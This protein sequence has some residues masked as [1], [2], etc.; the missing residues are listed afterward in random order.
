MEA[1]HWFAIGV[2]LAAAEA[3]MPGAVL[4]WTGIAALI[5]GV[6]VWFWPDLTWQ[7]QLFIFAAIAAVAVAVGLALRRRLA[8]RVETQMVNL[9]TS[10]F[11]GQR[12]ALERAIVNGRGEVKLG[13]TVWPV[14]GPDL[15]A[16]TS[17]VVT[18]TDGTTLQVA[19]AEQAAGGGGAGA[20]AT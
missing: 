17:V 2:A 3:L 9:G 12:G 16:G 13:D 5:L 11:V 14:T 8:P 15:P 6:I 19:P 4:L 18:G 20:G 1:W 10:R 7:T